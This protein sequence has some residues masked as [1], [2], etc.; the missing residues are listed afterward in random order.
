MYL[1]GIHSRSQRDRAADGEGPGAS[2]SLFV[3]CASRGG[4]LCANEFRALRKWSRR[5]TLTTS[6]SSGGGSP[7][8]ARSPDRRAQPRARGTRLAGLPHGPR[9]RHGP[10]PLPDMPPLPVAQPTVH[11]VA[12]EPQSPPVMVPAVAAALET[13]GT[14]E[15][16]ATR[17]NCAAGASLDADAVG[18]RGDGGASACIRTLPTWPTAGRSQPAP[19]GHRSARQAVVRDPFAPVGHRRRA[20]GRSHHRPRTPTASASHDAL[21]AAGCSGC[22]QKA[23]PHRTFERRCYGRTITG[24]RL[25]SPGRM[26]VGAAP[27]AGNVGQRRGRPCRDPV[28]SRPPRC[29]SARRP[30][31]ARSGDLAG[32]SPRSARV[33]SRQRPSSTPLLSARTRSRTAF[34]HLMRSARNRGRGSLAPHH[35]GRDSRC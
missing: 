6:Y 15:L 18:V 32:G 22:A 33:R 8:G 26:H 24:A 16:C 21:P 11:G 12:G 10:S 35:R 31:P 14:G 27:A 30:P 19:R 13:C 23:R 7:A 29:A 3:A 28:V 5:R 1:G 2:T 20:R 34:R 9:S 25:G 4:R 17:S